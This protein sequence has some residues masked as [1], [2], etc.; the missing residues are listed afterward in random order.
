MGREDVND[1]LGEVLMWRCS[2][3]YGIDVL[4]QI[5]LVLTLKGAL[6]NFMAVTGGVDVTGIEDI[7]VNDK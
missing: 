5:Q 6:E 1:K 7:D 3:F 2:Q 4:I